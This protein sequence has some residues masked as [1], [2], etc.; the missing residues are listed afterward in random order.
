[1]SWMIGYTLASIAG[2]FL[3]VRLFDY[4]LAGVVGSLVGIVRTCLFASVWTTITTSLG[5]RGFS[6]TVHHLR[7]RNKE[8]S[9]LIDPLPKHKLL[10]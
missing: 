5:M 8:V 6:R 3:V 4:V 1:M 9:T 10:Q 2:A 7:Q